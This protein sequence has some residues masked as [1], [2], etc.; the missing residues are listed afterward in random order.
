MSPFT[1]VCR[2]P[3]NRKGT[4]TKTN[5]FCTRR[6]HCKPINNGGWKF[7]VV[8]AYYLDASKSISYLNALKQTWVKSRRDVNVHISPTSLP[9]QRQNTRHRRF[10]TCT[11][12]C[13]SAAHA[14]KLCA[15]LTSKIARPDGSV[16]GHGSAP[17]LGPSSQKMVTRHLKQ[18]EA[19][20]TTQEGKTKEWCASIIYHFR[21]GQ[22]SGCYIDGSSESESG[23][24]GQ[25]KWFSLPNAKL[26][27]NGG[28][29]YLA[30]GGSVT[31]YNREVERGVYLRQLPQPH[32]P[33]ECYQQL[34]RH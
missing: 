29:A 17:L 32:C 5:S 26:W 15:K 33:H 6:T 20:I 12:C 16:W 22:V 21:F 27:R 31:I 4:C 7:W 18:I 14:T 9:I 30:D 11:K 24:E 28:R 1:N 2:F 25:Q 13:V 8:Y 34:R 19:S 10:I 3:C 23:L